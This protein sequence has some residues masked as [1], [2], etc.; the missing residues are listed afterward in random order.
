MSIKKRPKQTAQTV[1]HQINEAF[2]G[3][4]RYITRYIQSATANAFKCTAANIARDATDR[5]SHA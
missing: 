3:G 1:R 5:I 2:S 4:R